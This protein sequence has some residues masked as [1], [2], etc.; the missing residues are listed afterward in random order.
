MFCSR[1][2]ITNSLSFD[3][4][5]NSDQSKLVEL[6]DLAKAAKKGKWSDDAKVCNNNLIGSGQCWARGNISGIKSNA[7]GF[8]LR[9]PDASLHLMEKVKIK[10]C[11]KKVFDNYHLYV[12]CAYE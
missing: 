11:P 2:H 4:F 9:M 8:S 6:E 7:L 12:T 5:L 10:V 3:L 1:F